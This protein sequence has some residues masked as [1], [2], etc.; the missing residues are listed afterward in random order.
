MCFASGAS[1]HDKQPR[2]REGSSPLE[3]RGNSRVHIVNL[4]PLHTGPTG[5]ARYVV[6]QFPSAT[7]NK[8]RSAPLDRNCTVGRGARGRMA[9]DPV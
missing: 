6:E 3:R 4:S 1:P 7:I 9:R 8:V 5:R 2:S